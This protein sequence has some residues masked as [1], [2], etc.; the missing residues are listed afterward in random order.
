[1]VLSQHRLST[2]NVT[3][4]NPIPTPCFRNAGREHEVRTLP[5][6]CRYQPPWATQENQGNPLYCIRALTC[7]RKTKQNQTKTNKELPL[8][9][10][11]CPK[12]RGLAIP[13]LSCGELG[14]EGSWN[15]RHGRKFILRTLR[16]TRP[17]PFPGSRFRIL[18]MA[19]GLIFRK[20][21]ASQQKVVYEPC[22]LSG[23]GTTIGTERLKVWPRS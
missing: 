17:C 12:G 23:L 7:H 9:L 2:C 1:M 19:S 22:D 3:L 14:R 4:E 16:S 21:L 15:P 13:T 5:G 6:T 11:V 18:Q 8:G 20:L 10:I